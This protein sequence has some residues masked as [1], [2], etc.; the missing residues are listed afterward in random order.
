MTMWRYGGIV[1]PWRAA[2]DGRKAFPPSAHAMASR[3][4]VFPWLL[5]PPMIVSPEADG[6]ILTALTRLTFSISSLLIFMLM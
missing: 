6:S 1:D 5:S 2:S 4:L 3:T